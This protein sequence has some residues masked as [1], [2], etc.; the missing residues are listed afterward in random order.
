MRQHK[1]M[2]GGELRTWRIMHGT[3]YRYSQTLTTMQTS[4]GDTDPAMLSVCASYLSACWMGGGA[5]WPTLRE[6]GGC[7]VTQGDAVVDVLVGRGVEIGHVMQCALE[8]FTAAVAALPASN[9]EVAEAVD[10]TE[11]PAPLTPV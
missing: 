3:T 5:D 1:H 8:L 9:E 6:C 2:I 10:F 7:Q 4:A 11:E